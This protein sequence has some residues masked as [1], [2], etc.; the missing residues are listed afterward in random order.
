[1]KIDT[2][3]EEYLHAAMHAGVI[4]DIDGLKLPPEFFPDI[5]VMLMNEEISGRLASGLVGYTL[6]HGLDI[7]EMEVM[8]PR[9]VSVACL[10]LLRPYAIPERPDLVEIVARCTVANNKYLQGKDIE[11]SGATNVTQLH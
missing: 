9:S 11:E 8:I 6:A 5:V 10:E 7:T 1:M 2:L 4:R 3:I